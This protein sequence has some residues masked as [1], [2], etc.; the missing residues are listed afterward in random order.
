MSWQ[1]IICNTQY[2]VGAF[3]TMIIYIHA[4][5]LSM[6]VVMHKIHKNFY[7]T[8]NLEPIMLLKFP[9]HYF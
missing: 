3:L 7:P 9:T 8:V 6:D 5:K 4:L 2:Y 1:Y